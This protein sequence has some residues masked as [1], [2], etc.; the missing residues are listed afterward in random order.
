MLSKLRSVPALLILL[1][2]LAVVGGDTDPVSADVPSTTM[3]VPTT[4]A[5]NLSGVLAH[6]DGSVSVTNNECPGYVT[7]P[8][9]TADSAVTF[10]SGA[11]PINNVPRIMGSYQAQ[12]CQ[13][14]VVAGVDGTIYTTQVTD[15]SGSGYKLMARRDWQALW[16]RQFTQIGCSGSAQVHSLTMGEDGN[17]Y[18]KLIWT[19][20]SCGERLVSVD[21]T[22]G[23][24]NFSVSLPGTGTLSRSIYIPEVMP[25]TGGVAVLSGNS[26]YYYD[27]D[28]LTLSTATTFSPSLNG[29]AIADVAYST[30]TGRV[31]IATTK[32]VS[33]C[34]TYEYHLYYKNPSDTSISEISLGGASLGQLYATPSGGVAAGLGAGFTYFDSSGS[35]VYQRNFNSE[36]G[37]NVISNSMV[38]DDDGNVIMRRVADYYGGTQDRNVIVDSFSPTGTATRLFSSASMGGSGFDAYY[39]L[40][41]MEQAIGGGY[42][43]LVLCHATSGYL[44][45]CNSGNSPVVLQLDVD[46]NTDYPRAGVY[47]ELGDRPEYVALGDSFSSGEGVPDFS[48]P[49]DSNGCHRSLFAYPL[50][51]ASVESLRL[52]A[53]RACSG[54]STDDVRD[55]MN[56]ERGQLDALSE[57]TDIVTI[58][59]GG[60]DA[61]FR[62]FAEQCVLGTCDSASS[63]YQDTMDAIDNV[64]PGNLDDL[65]EDISD[66]APNAEVYVVGYPDESPDTSVSC[67]FL[68]NGEKVAI[69][70]VAV[71]LKL[72]IQGAVENAGSGFHYVDPLDTESPFWGHELCTED[73]YFSQVTTPIVYSF[74]PNF[75][76]QSAYAQLV[77]DS[78][79]G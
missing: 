36:T 19:A 42:L 23:A 60:N 26:V 43:Y 24:T 68:S 70:T 21:P 40:T 6:G 29:G 38:V 35:V 66:A 78:L 13:N 52:S 34:C 12:I 25:Y 30:D 69:S 65:Y 72:T 33:G 14:H 7:A 2:M 5:P 28:G 15:P 67:T 62:Q 61:H 59:V 47:G 20:G 57:S 41:S 53:F 39:S 50:Q 17:L 55:G 76:G 31:F 51:V 54:A 64:L 71:E 22:T 1:A 8:S 4:V 9:S 16:A 74:H 27:Y 18:A 75:L 46:S 49:S 77:A 44:S 32:Y 37:A 79:N 58:S 56:G 10:T 73:A 48:V 45:N 63:E 3:A 11:Q